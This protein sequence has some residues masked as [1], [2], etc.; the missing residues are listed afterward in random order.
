LYYLLKRN[1]SI[2]V[3]GMRSDIPF[4]KPILYCIATRPLY[5]SANYVDFLAAS[6]KA[7]QNFH[8]NNIITV[9]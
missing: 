3:N 1:S 5:K 9:A 2:F 6:T 8:H 7:S 4:I